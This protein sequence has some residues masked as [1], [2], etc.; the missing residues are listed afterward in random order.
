MDPIG[1][2]IQRLGF[3]ELFHY[4]KEAV[5]ILLKTNHNLLLRAS[6]GAGKTLPVLIYLHKAI[7]L[8]NQRAI[9]AVPSVKLVKDKQN[10]IQKVVAPLPIE[11]ENF[12]NKL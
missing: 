6:T 3:Q 8:D 7:N 10:E 5:D 11:L 4:Q 9:Y 2:V 1:E 12:L